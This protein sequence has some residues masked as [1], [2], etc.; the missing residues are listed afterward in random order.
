[1]NEK[2][3]IIIGVSGLIVVAIAIGWIYYALNP[4]AWDDFQAEMSGESEFAPAA[5]SS[6]SRSLPKFTRPARTL[7]ALMASGNIEAEEVLVAAE[8]GGR[9]TELEA[10][11]GDDVQAGDLLLQLDRRALLA[12]QEGAKANVAQAE[13]ALAVAQAITLPPGIG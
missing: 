2:T 9:I 1:M 7:G 13:G 6:S 5:S 4:G 11:E 12:Q 8:L 3:K 10:N